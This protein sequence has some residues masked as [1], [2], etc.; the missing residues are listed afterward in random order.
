MPK[1][2][3]GQQ[4]SIRCA[5]IGYGEAFNMGRA[6]CGWI[7]ATE[8]LEAIAVCDIDPARTAAAKQDFP[9]LETYNDTAEMLARADFDLAVVVLPH[10]LHAPVALQ[11]LRAGKHVVVEKP[12]CLKVREA[13]AM[14]AAAQEAGVMLSVF[15]NRRWDGDFLALKEV[16]DKGLLGEIFHVEM[17]GGGYGHPGYWWRSDK[18]VSG[19]AF[20][21]W[22]AHL[23]DWLL[24]LLPGRVTGVTGFFHKLKWHDV[25]NEDNVEA[26]LRFENGA[27]AHVQLSHLAK[28]GKERWRILGSEGALISADG[29]FRLL[30]NVN[31]YPAEARVPYRDSQWDAYYRNIAAHLLKGEEL[32]VKPEEAR[33]VIAILE[34][35]EK[36]SRRGRTM[37][38]PYE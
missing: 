19:G 35:A 3:K 37:K 9:N 16:V 13:D 28:V 26:V 23:L 32:A 29:H 10:N 18:K 14:I 1:R 31:G 36:S 7:N 24:N 38:V 34:T 11:C 8:G 22:G 15:H 6:H 25:T 33:R 21:D 17:F 20:Y 4:A 12:M 30:T 5:V 27:L 2:R